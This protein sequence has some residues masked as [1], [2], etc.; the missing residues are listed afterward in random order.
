MIQLPEQKSEKEKGHISVI[1]YRFF[2]LLSF[3]LIVIA[4]PQNDMC[5][6]AGAGG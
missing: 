2:P 4:K 5:L 6:Y 3:L 1:H